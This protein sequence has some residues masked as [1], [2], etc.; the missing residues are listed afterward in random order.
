MAH[1]YSF[2]NGET[3]TG[4]SDLRTILSYCQTKG[5]TVVTYAHM[6]DTFRSSVL[7]ERIAALEKG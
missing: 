2:G 1:D 6:F 7:E 5:I 4:E 3:F